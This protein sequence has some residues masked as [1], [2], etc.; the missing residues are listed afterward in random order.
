M[1]GTSV[2]SIAAGKSAGVA[3]GADLYFIADTAC[4]QDTYGSIDFA[5]HAKVIRRILEINNS[6]P[7][8]RKIR[9]ISMSLR[10]RP[11]SKGFQEIMDAVREADAAGVFVITTGT[12]MTRNF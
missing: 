6:L 5:C 7:G 2:A 8:G 1:H 3:P 4:S 10:W 9:V 12:N 11:L